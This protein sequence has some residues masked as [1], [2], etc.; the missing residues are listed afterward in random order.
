MRS[1]DTAGRKVL[2]QPSYISIDIYLSRFEF[3]RYMGA[4]AIAER[5]RDRC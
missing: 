4:G 1:L 2:A 5:F 3:A